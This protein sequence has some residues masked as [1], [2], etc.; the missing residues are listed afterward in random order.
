MIL[1]A[2]LI[3]LSYYGAYALLFGSFENTD[4]WQLFIQTIP[5]L[6]VVKLFAFLFAGVYRGIW[7]YTSISDFVTFFKGVA[8]GSVLS[9]VAVLLFYRFQN[10]SRAVFILDG[11]ILFR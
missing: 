7:R 3:T 10:F 6:I 2:I 1:D 11:L 5:I 4:N 9:V 8:I